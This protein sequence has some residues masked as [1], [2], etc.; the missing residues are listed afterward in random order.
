MSH[1]R[2]KRQFR[3]GN[4]CH[5]FFFRQNRYVCRCSG[6]GITMSIRSRAFAPNSHD[7]KNVL[8]AYFAGSMINSEFV[9]AEYQPS[10]VTQGV[11][12]SI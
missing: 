6:N 7:A 8:A 3:S 2:H 9:D 1:R 4:M 10:I 5:L 12:A 11:T